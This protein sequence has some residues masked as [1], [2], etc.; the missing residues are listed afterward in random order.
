MMSV[1]EMEDFLADNS[2]ILESDWTE[3]FTNGWDDVV[4][5]WQITEEDITHICTPRSSALEALLAA[6]AELPED[7]KEQLTEPAGDGKAWL[8]F[9]A[10]DWFASMRIEYVREPNKFDLN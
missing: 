7:T 2:D 9:V 1:E 5:L 10:P 6:G 3:A 8:L 4:F